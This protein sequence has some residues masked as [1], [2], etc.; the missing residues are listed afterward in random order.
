MNGDQRRTTDV[1]IRKVI[2][3]YED[4]ILTSLSSQNNNSVFID[5][6][7]KEKKTL[8][9]QFMGFEIFDKLCGQQSDEIKDV[10]AVLK[11]LNKMIGNVNYQI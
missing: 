1:N 2:G 6:T 5:K 8:L 9:A 11:T 3:T 10:S 4:F 7:Q